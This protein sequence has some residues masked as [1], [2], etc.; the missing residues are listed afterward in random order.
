MCI[1]REPDRDVQR[2]DEQVLEEIRRLFA[3]YRDLAR[4]ETERDETPG[5]EPEE[6]PVLIER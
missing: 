3:R 4:H 5:A 1:G 6:A 2:D